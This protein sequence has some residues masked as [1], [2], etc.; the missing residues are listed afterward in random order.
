MKKG[1]IRREDVWEAVQPHVVELVRRMTGRHARQINTRQLIR[2]YGSTPLTIP[3][4]PGSTFTPLAFDEGLADTMDGWSVSDPTK[5]YAARSGY[6]TAGGCWGLDDTQ[7]TVASRMI[8]AVR[9]NGT[10]MLARNDISTIA[11]RIF[12]V[13]VTTGSFWLN[14]GEYVQ[15][16]ALHDQGGDRTAMAA[17]GTSQHNLNGWLEGR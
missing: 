15:I 11:G 13:S 17:T 4:A 12:I 14:A 9:A 7:N 16:L 10:T 2:V 5:L 3:T 8:V 1:L 6:F